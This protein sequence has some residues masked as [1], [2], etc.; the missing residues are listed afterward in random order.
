[1]QER[2]LR[3]MYVYVRMVVE[4]GTSYKEWTVYFEEHMENPLVRNSG[5][6]DFIVLL[7]VKW[8]NVLGFYS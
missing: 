3:K 4:S 8:T 6:N 5:A 1:M 2:L 7:A